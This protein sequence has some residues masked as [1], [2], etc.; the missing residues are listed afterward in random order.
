[1]RRIC[2]IAY[3]HGLRIRLADNSPQGSY[4]YSYCLTID[5]PASVVNLRT[6]P[7]GFE[8]TAR[9]D[10]LPTHLAFGSE[11]TRS[12]ARSQ[13]NIDAATNWVDSHPEYWT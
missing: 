2:T 3:R 10:S 13:A 11:P 7:E 1:M 5:P 4:G 8:H 12:A 6:C 9:Y